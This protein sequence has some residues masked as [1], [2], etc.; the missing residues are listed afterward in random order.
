MHS[1]EVPLA[2]EPER[3]RS[4]AEYEH[5]SHLSWYCADLGP[6]SDF[7]AAAREAGGLFRSTPVTVETAREALRFTVGDERPRDVRIERA[8]EADGINGEEVSWSVGFGPRTHGWF[9]K[10]AARS[11]ALPG[12]LALYDH[13]H[14]KF[15]GKEK[16]ADGPEGPLAAVQDFRDTYYG[17][18]AF[19][20]ALAR[21]G[22]AVLIHDT[23]LWGSRRFP[24]EVMPEAD[25]ALADRIGAT[26]GHGGAGSDI[27][28]Y[29]GA[30]Y[31]HEHQIAKYCTLLGTSLAAVTA[32]EDRVALNYLRSRDDV[33]AERLGCI[34]FS[35]GG[36]RA[37]L[38]GATADGVAARAI[39]GMM[40]TYEECLDR[41]VTPHTWM[42]FPTGWSRHGDLPDIAAC[43]AP[44]PLL[45]QF[46]LGD[47]LFTPKGMRDANSRIAD[48]Y[49]RAEAPEA[50][51]ADF[52]EGPH[53][54]DVPMQEAAFAWLLSHLGP[55]RSA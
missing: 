11:G 51:R 5:P 27:L 15:F 9:L 16:I 39:V 4:C 19:A 28:R 7:V 21:Q 31:L 55:A 8:W 23:F 49:A 3:R 22:F 30:A 52:R 42:L 10:L 35:G 48:Y 26:L 6:Y 24:I 14:Y 20:N 17:G 25:L 37:A 34:G 47:S 46:A 33:D 54:F 2:E 18:R 41:H 40:T 12:V 13:G 45:V 44:A 32:F 53:R 50:Y 43:P 38:L 36:L 1:S 29:H